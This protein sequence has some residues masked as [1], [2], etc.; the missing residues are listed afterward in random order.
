MTWTDDPVRDWDRHCAEEERWLATR[1]ICDEC[2]EP[3]TEDACYEIDGEYICEHCI[4]DYVDE[5]FRTA[6]P[7]YENDY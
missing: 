6:T 4:R 1:R 2:E 7:V 5:H 3:I